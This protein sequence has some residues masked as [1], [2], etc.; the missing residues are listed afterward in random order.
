MVGFQYR[1]HPALIKLK[2]LLNRKIIGKLING[3]IVNGEY[4]PYWHPYEDYRR[5]YASLK[6]LG[7]GAILTQ[8]HDFDYSIFIFGMPKSVLYGGKLSSLDIDVEDSVAISTMFEYQNS[9]LVM[10]I[11]L[12]YISW[13]SRRNIKLFGEDGSINCDLNNNFL[14]VQKRST[15]EVFKY[16]YSSISRNDIFIK[17]LKN[18]IAFVEGKEKPLVDL[19]EG[20]KSLKFALAAK[21]SLK[22]GM[23]L[24]IN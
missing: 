21:S 12:D 20:I 13:P 5:S 7:G 16:D 19:E 1:Y 9:P 6:K 22:K 14:E 15:N 18:F 17:E 3:Q 4:L 11:N 23:L 2:E 10:N 24:N 8:I